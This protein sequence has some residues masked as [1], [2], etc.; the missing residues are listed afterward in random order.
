MP[1][2]DPELRRRLALSGENPDDYEDPSVKS[3]DVVN[4]AKPE[5]SFWD[6]PLYTPPEN[7]L[8]GSG[9][10]L[11][12]R[13]GGPELHK[14]VQET[15]RNAAIG[16]STP[17]N[18]G[19]GLAALIPGIAPFVMGHFAAQG[20]EQ[21]GQ[22]LGEGSVN[23]QTGNREALGKNIVNAGMGGLM[24]FGP[25][26]HVE[27]KVK[28]VK[29]LKETEVPPIIE[30]AKKIPTSKDIM[31]LFNEKAKFEKGTPEYEKANAAF[32]EAMGK[33]FPKQV[34]LIEPTNVEESVKEIEKPAEAIKDRP[35]TYKGKQ[36]VPDG[37]PGGDVH[38]YDLTED[39]P[40]HVKGSTVSERTLKEKGFN[41]EIPKDEPLPPRIEEKPPVIKGDEPPVIKPEESSS[42]E[43]N[44]IFWPV[45]RSESSRLPHKVKEVYNNFSDDLSL[46][47]GKFVND[48]HQK[49]SK[50]TGMDKVLKKVQSP[51]EYFKQNTPDMEAVVNYRRDMMEGIPPKPLTPLQ[52]QINNAVTESNKSVRDSQIASSV[53]RKVSG[54]NPNYLATRIKPEI[55]KAIT[56]QDT[57]RTGRAPLDATAKSDALKVEYIKNEADQIVKKTPTVLPAEAIKVATKHANEFIQSLRSDMQGNKGAHYGPIDE[58]HGFFVP[59][60]WQSNNLLDIQSHYLDRVA[61]RFAYDKNVIKNP[62]GHAALDQ[63]KGN[64]YVDLV[65]K[66]MSGN[67]YN[68]MG[69][70]RD[71]FAIVKSAAQSF[72]SSGRNI[73][74]APF[75]G[76][77]HMGVLQLPKNSLKALTTMKQNIAEGFQSGRIRSSMHSIELDGGLEDLSNTLKRVRDVVSDLDTRNWGEKMSRAISIGQARFASLDFLAE[78]AKGKLSVTGKKWFNDFGKDTNWKSGTLTPEELVKISGR[79]V[80]SVQGTYDLRSLPKWAVQGDLAPYFSLAK[81]S[82][83]KSNNYMKY[84]VNPAKN[85][86]YLPLLT[87]T[88]GIFLGGEA[89]KEL[90]EKMTGRKANEATFKEI[91]EGQKEGLNTKMAIFYSATGLAAAASHL[92]IIGDTLKSIL[93]V[94]YGKNRPQVYNN[95]MVEAAGNIAS[96]WLNAGATAYKE[97][98]SFDLVKEAIARTLTDNIQLYRVLNDHLNQDKINQTDKSNKE[99]DL[100]VFDTMSGND[101]TDRTSPFKQDLGDLK[102]QKYKKEQDIDK[103]LEILPDLLDEANK[104]AGDDPMK[105]KKELG[106]ITGENYPTMPNMKTEPINFMKYYEYLKT[107]KGEQEADKI[108]DDFLEHQV[109]KKIKT[110]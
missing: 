20:A 64:D 59:R 50:L 90:Y 32:L 100:R 104:K 110:L 53:G 35:F 78:Q 94:T 48:F 70:S 108:V 106:K 88:V 98:M 75:Y 24:A 13:L 86:N 15:M 52:E 81:W 37:F 107:T 79:Y 17:K 23:V 93:D 29:E 1:V 42:S 73:V 102:L 60:S 54:E 27:G 12:S 63:Y 67:L 83:D 99:R 65:H 38:L 41:P 51:V 71:I 26:G 45:L 28:P 16:L 18:I 76:A 40:G 10:S 46:M 92:G 19:L 30:Q 101:I 4:T 25:L 34:D 43:P 57:Q 14:G 69:K 56:Q 72:Y 74:S 84:V 9:L 109:K 97:G 33:A 66:E 22:A 55:I 44:E 89:V 77:Q 87:S 103:S 11:L 68:D 21:L 47:R 31:N 58:A 2:T 95:M 39:I 96:T 3:P 82:I 85:G 91:R 8:E 105:L 61:R 36:E 7:A 49:L 62:A 5:V 6:K 80:D